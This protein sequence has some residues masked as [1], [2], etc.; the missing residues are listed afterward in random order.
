M[1]EIY[2]LVILII[3]ILLIV[4]WIWIGIMMT[5]PATDCLDKD[6]IEDNMDVDTIDFNPNLIMYDSN[7]NE[8]CIC[9]EEKTTTH[10]DFRL[11]S[12]LIF[13]ENFTWYKEEGIELCNMQYNDT[14][15]MM[16]NTTECVNERCSMVRYTNE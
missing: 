1:N 14:E 16:W 2:K 13:Y 11:N 9:V 10:V 5:F 3:L 8:E 15:L 12:C 4:D 7:Y 6:S